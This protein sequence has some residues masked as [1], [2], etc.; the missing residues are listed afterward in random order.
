[1]KDAEIISTRRLLEALLAK[2]PE[3]GYVRATRVIYAKSDGRE[4]MPV[5]LVFA[6]W[7]RFTRRR[8]A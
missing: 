3:D 7:L 4:R 6:R 8:S 1:M 5:R 2:A